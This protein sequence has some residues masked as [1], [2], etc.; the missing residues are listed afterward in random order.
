GDQ[1]RLVDHPV[2]EREQAE[3]EV[4]RGIGVAGH[5]GDSRPGADRGIGINDDPVLQGGIHARP[6]DMI[7]GWISRA[8]SGGV[9]MPTG[10]DAG[11]PAQDLGTQFPGPPFLHS[12]P[13]WPPELPEDEP[14]ALVSQPGARV[15]VRWKP[16][17]TRNG[18]W[19][20]LW[21]R[22]TTSSSVIVPSAVAS[23]K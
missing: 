23:T 11:R 13:R 16:A 21:N 6:P 15:F 20:R 17:A 1:L 9:G 7:V 2:L 19:A 10:D 18:L 22:T 3:Q 8:H 14:R 4:A 12:R 5:G